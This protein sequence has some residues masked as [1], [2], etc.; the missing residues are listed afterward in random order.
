MTPKVLF[1]L[2]KTI[3]FLS[4]LCFPLNNLCAR[5]MTALLGCRVDRVGP[6]IGKHNLLVSLRPRYQTSQ[7]WLQTGNLIRRN[8]LNMKLQVEDSL[9]IQLTAK[10]LL[11]STLLLLL[12]HLPPELTLSDARRPLS[13]HLIS[14]SPSRYTSLKQQTWCH[15]PA[16]RLG[17]PHSRPYLHLLRLTSRADQRA[18]VNSGR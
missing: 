14:Y 17:R 2:P 16:H 7:R 11:S 15:G 10:N 3:D 6:H 4:P 1:I 13:Q 5:I 9:F 12:L 8:A 18:P